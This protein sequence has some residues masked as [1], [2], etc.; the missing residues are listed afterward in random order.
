MTEHPFS[1]ALLSPDLAVPNGIVDP[2][3]NA[4]PKR[5]AVYRNNVTIGLSRALADNFPAIQSLVGPAF[6]QAMAIEFVRACPPN[7]PLLALYGTAF[8]KFLAEFGP[9]QSLGYLPDVARLE[10]A[11][12]HSYHAADHDPRAGEVLG[13]LDEQSLLQ[14]RLR[15]APS[16]QTVTSDWPVLDIWNAA[17]N[18]GPKPRHQAQSVLVTRPEFDPKP[19]LLPALSEPFLQALIQMS[20][21]G[22]A[23]ADHPKAD[24]IA[25]LTLL[26]TSGAIAEVLP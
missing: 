3:G 16:A 12:R 22:Q 17:L 2:K 21:I 14:A 13:T 10:L 24:A 15:I 8:P 9:A 25:T 1:A 11:L 23:I 6:F 20:P 18:N 26:A 4:A 7:S 19:H 5:F